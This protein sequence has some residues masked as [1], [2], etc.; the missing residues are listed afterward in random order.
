MYMIMHAFYKHDAN[1]RVCDINLKID[2]LKIVLNISD[3]YVTRNISRYILEPIKKQIE[4][5][6]DYIFQYKNI[7]NRR[8]IDKCNIRFIAKNKR[9][10]F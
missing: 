2:E 6:T 9:T 4:S 5:N 7:I 3:K 1:K 8:K 10:I